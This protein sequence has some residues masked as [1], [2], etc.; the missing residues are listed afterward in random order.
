MK[1]EEF[2]KH[3]LPETPG[4]Y[5]FLDKKHTNKSLPNKE[6]ILYVGKATSLKDRVGSYFNN[7]L[8]N[9]RGVKIQSMIENVKD[10]F[11]LK[12]FLVRKNLLEYYDKGIHHLLKW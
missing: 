10:I 5:F 1:K 12:P 2:K 3:K 6:S 7:D 4:V 11:F 9:T 8:I